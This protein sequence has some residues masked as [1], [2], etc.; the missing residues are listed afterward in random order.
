M[1]EDT[2]SGKSICA[3]G[4]RACTFSSV[5]RAGKEKHTQISTHRPVTHSPPLV[6]LGLPRAGAEAYG[7]G[8]QFAGAMEGSHRPSLTSSSWRMKPKLLGLLSSPYHECSLVAHTCTR[9]EHSRAWVSSGLPMFIQRHL[10]KVSRAPHL[11][12]CLH[13]VLF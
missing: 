10:L 9:H 8:R 4:C 5:S 12:S 13:L 3:G 1:L 6:T 2:H 11:P 7:R